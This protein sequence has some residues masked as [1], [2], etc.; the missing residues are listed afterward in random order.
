[1]K[2]LQCK[3]MQLTYKTRPRIWVAII[4]GRCFQP[5][6]EEIVEAHHRLVDLSTPGYKRGGSLRTCRQECSPS[7]KTVTALG[8]GVGIR[9]GYRFDGRHIG[10]K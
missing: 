2:P 9:L 8:P 3:N 1:M 6:S 4:L 10:R 7:S 5:Q